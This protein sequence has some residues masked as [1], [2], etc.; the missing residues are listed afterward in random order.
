MR[1]IFTLFHWKSF[2]PIAISISLLYNLF[3]KQLPLLVYDKLIISKRSCFINLERWKSTDDIKYSFNKF[4]K[5]SGSK[6]NKYVNRAKYYKVEIVSRRCLWETL[7]GTKWQAREINRIS[8]VLIRV[9]GKRACGFSF[10]SNTRLA[11]SKAP[12]ASI[13]TRE[14]RHVFNIWKA[15]GFSLV[16]ITHFVDLT[17]DICSRGFWTFVMSFACYMYNFNFCEYI[18]AKAV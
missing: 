7:R 11:H 18:L 13:Y 12:F 8:D 10:W 4:K 17:V 1:R 3:I 15:F 16:S 14:R 2:K 6:L 9:R 5:V